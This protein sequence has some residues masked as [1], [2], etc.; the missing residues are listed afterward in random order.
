MNLSWIDA[1]TECEYLGGYLAEPSVELEQDFL[2]SIVRIIEDTT[3]HANWWIGLSDVSHESSWYWQHNVTP[4][5]FSSWVQGR[6]SNEKPNKDDCVVMFSGDQSY[7]WFDIECND[8]SSSSP[9]SFICQK[10]NDGIT[11]TTKTSP[12]STSITPTSAD[13]TTSTYIGCDL[14]N[15]WKEFEQNCYKGFD[16]FT[17]WSEAKH[18]CI[19]ENADLVSIHSESED[20]FVFQLLSS[21]SSDIWLGLYWDGYDFV[22]DDGSDFDYSN[23]HSGEPDFS[24]CGSKGKASGTWYDISC[25]Y[26]RN[27]ACKR[28]I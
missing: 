18:R 13:T 12:T 17:T 28:P 9:V 6:P 21:W 24:G 11:T 27:F 16:D 1:Q 8:L 14:L 7:D 5:T 2:K 22:Y 20:E 25:S 15:D 23:W 3:H 19:Q 26:T 4:I 10:V